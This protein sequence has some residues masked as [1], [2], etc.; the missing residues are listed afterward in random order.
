MK[1][2]VLAALA[3][4]ALGLALAIRAQAPSDDGPRYN[5][6]SLL[7]PDYREWIF[8]GSGLG[9]TYQATPSQSPAFTNV[10]VNPSSY[11]AFLQTGRWPDRTVLLVEVRASAS[12]HSINQSGRY[13]TNQVALEGHVKDARLGGDGWG[14]FN[15]SR[16]SEGPRLTGD[17][18][19]GCVDCHSKNAAVD[20]TFV[21]FYPNL[22]EVARQKGTAR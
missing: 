13:Q 7:R 10:F 18:V 9:M 8:L 19:A 12:E 16:G 21:Q 6:T 14:F 22:L 4:Y 1:K 17:A 3:V 5:G 20:T 15:L 2:I 11:R